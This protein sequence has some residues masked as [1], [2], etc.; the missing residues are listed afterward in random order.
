MTA[1]APTTIREARGLEDAAERALLD[2]AT[3]TSAVL[4]EA[5]VH[6]LRIA[7]QWAVAHPAVD[8]AET[9]RG[10]SLP[11]VLSRPETLGGAGT[12]AVAAF[13]SEPL[14]V[15]LGCSPAAASALLADTLDL[16]H[17]L[18]LLWD[19]VQALV[20]PVWKAR[21]V[22]DRTRSL[23]V[24]GA[25]WVDRQLAGRVSSVGRAALDRLV[26]AAAARCDAE[27][28]QDRERASRMG[29]D[30]VL[31]HPDPRLYSGTSELR[32]TGDTLDLTRF[33]DVVCAEAEAMGACGDT[34]DLGARKAK[35]LGVIAD[36]QARLDLTSLLGTGAPVD[37]PE[38]PAVHEEA[39]RSATSRRDAKVRLYLHASLADVVAGDPGA[40]GTA[41]SLGPV[42]L[43]RIR[44]WAGRSRL[45]ILPV[46]H[47][48]ADDRWSVDRHDPPPRMAEQVRLRDETCTF[49]WCAR[50][51]RQCDLDHLVPYDDPGG[52]GGPPA[53]SSYDDPGGG[54]PD[55]TT[56]DGP[57]PDGTTPANLAPLCRRH[58]RAKTA[59]VWSYERVD[60]GTYLW[61][62]PGG[63]AVMV[64]TR[65]TVRVPSG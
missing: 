24:E 59:G 52:G 48:A 55:G 18:P 50:P 46:L 54:P 19:Q 1:T 8:A 40:T 15:A 23:S 10:P 45:T 7:Y 4:R 9:P 49:P 37:D 16:H 13:T 5:E 53:A 44:D 65:G 2:E 31:V 29:W 20:A 26:A 60:A 11:D 12:P 27:P 34:D 21:R 25:R 35:A 47:V 62:G 17:R 58:H 36:A 30:V 56:P 14:A 41:E 51:A 33:H 32:A 43:E 6:Q 28:L 42:T 3:E 39:R 57:T 38:Y 63:L 22:A 61:A 64:T